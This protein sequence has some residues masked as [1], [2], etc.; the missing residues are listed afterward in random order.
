MIS[1]WYVSSF[2]WLCPLVV[3]KVNAW[4]GCFSSGC[5][6]D[7]PLLAA[8]SRMARVTLQQQFEWDF[9]RWDGFGQ[10]NPDDRHPLLSDWE[11]ELL[12]PVSYHCTIVVSLYVVTLL[13]CSKAL[14]KRQ[15]MA[16][17]L[18]GTEVNRSMQVLLDFVT[19]SKCLSFVLH[20]LCLRPLSRWSSL[21]VCHMHV[22]WCNSWEMVLFWFSVLSTLSNW[23]MEFDRWA[24]A[25]VKIIYKVGGSPLPLHLR[26][27]DYSACSEL[28]LSLIS[29]TSRNRLLA[30]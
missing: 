2:F 5:C 28:R 7:F 12:R 10:D 11:E 17:M 24:P 27:H 14:W 16:A 8:R 29:G 25:V 20:S 30:A 22:S 6:L 3:H 23:A 15:G 13:V 18:L 21:C 9:G 4:T 26:F 19:F 1:K